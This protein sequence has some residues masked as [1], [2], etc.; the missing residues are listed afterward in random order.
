M[1]GS[2]SWL[3]SEKCPVDK[4]KGR[5]VSEVL[6]VTIRK[7]RGTSHARR[8]RAAGQIP[9]ILYGHGE[10]NVSL[11]IVAEQV[12]MAIRH[13]THLVELK[14][15]VA[16]SALIRDVQWDPFGINVLHVDFARVQAGESV[17]VAVNVELRGEAPGTKSGGIIEHVLHELEID[18]PVSVIPDKFEVKINSLE[19]GGSIFAKDIE[20]PEGAKLLTDADAVVVQCVQPAAMIEEEI[21]AVSEEPEIIGKKPEEG[22]EQE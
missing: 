21:P 6:N 10:E 3:A 18:C 11:S 13:G 15:D 1:L 5:L 12:E 4:Q 7:T 8:Q 20:L 14:G 2:I 9:A 16:Q 19:L 22:E 17:E